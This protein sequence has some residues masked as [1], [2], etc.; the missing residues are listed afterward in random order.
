MAKGKYA[1]CVIEVKDPRMKRDL[2]EGKVTNV[3]EFGTENFEKSAVWFHSCIVYAPGAGYGA[4][5]IWERIR[6]S[7]EKEVIHASRHKHPADEVFMFLGTDPQHPDDLGGEVE[8]W[9][10]KGEDE[11]RYRFTKSTIV[12]VPGNTWHNPQWFREVHR[13]FIEVVI[14]VL[15]EYASSEKRYIEKTQ[16]YPPAFEKEYGH[17]LKEYRGT[18]E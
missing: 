17:I 12:Y 8:F 16:E 6:P 4:G 15:P 9:L 10:G 14:L 7:G 1:K 18:T 3:L 11:E 5:D 2:F 13:P